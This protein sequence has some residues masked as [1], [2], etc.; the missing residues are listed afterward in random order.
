MRDQAR[1]DGFPLPWFDDGIAPT[2]P[3]DYLSAMRTVS[4]PMIRTSHDNWW[5]PVPGWAAD[6]VR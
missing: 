4:E 5:R 1:T 2:G 6:P 3:T